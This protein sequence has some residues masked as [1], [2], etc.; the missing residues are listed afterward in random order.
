[1]S[2]VSLLLLTFV[3]QKL[4]FY[5][6]NAMMNYLSKKELLKKFFGGPFSSLWHKQISTELQQ[7]V[8]IKW[9]SR[10]LTVRVAP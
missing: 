6:A 5:R 3:V 4:I 9:V 10:H 8:S 2:R 1:M 7:M